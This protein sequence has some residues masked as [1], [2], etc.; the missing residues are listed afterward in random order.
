MIA[1]A[2]CAL[3]QVVGDNTHSALRRGEEEGS[4]QYICC[5]KTGQAACV[6]LCVTMCGVCVYMCVS[7]C[8]CMCGVLGEGC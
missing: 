5:W 3:S 7:M 1:Q 8:V 6:C 4:T 2:I